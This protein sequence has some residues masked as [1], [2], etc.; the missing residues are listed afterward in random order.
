MLSELIEFNEWI[1]L[2]FGDSLYVWNEVAEESRSIRLWIFVLSCGDDIINRHLLVTI[3]VEPVEYEMQDSFRVHQAE[4]RYTSQIVHKEDLPWGLSRNQKEESLQIGK[5][6][7][8]GV[9]FMQ[10]LGY[11][12]KGEEGLELC[13][14]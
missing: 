7:E 1:D 5:L 9:S 2:V 12:I 13:L 11:I 10:G 6:S 14:E 8:I 4:G 3:F